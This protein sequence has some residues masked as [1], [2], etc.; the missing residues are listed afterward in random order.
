MEKTVVITDGCILTKIEKV[1]DI[2]GFSLKV[3]VTPVR[4]ELHIPVRLVI[5]VGETK[6]VFEALYHPQRLAIF[7][8]SNVAAQLLGLVCRELIRLEAT[9]IKLVDIHEAVTHFMKM[10]A[11]CYEGGQEPQSED[12]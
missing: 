8:Q 12:D 11:H 4:M 1:L 10:T 6:E 5:Q 7:R 2:R 9:G 3:V